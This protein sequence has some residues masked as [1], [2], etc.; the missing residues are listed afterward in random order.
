MELCVQHKIRSVA[1][2][3]ISTGIF[4]YPLAPATHT[5]I[6]F[7]RKWL[8]HKSNR[9]KVQITLFVPRSCWLSTP[10]CK[11]QKFMFLPTTLGGRLFLPRKLPLIVSPF[12]F[13]LIKLDLFTS[14][15]LVPFPDIFFVLG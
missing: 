1:F 12:R 4:G 11:S 9:K 7:I 14:A 10:I 6:R 5:A 8:E 13:S 3:S 2:C 15:C